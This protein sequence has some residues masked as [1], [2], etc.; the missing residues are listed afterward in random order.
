[1]AKV[2]IDTDDLRGAI[3]ELMQY[4][5]NLEVEK[6]LYPIRYRAKSWFFIVCA[7]FV[8]SIVIGFL[9]KDWTMFE[10]YRG[11]GIGC[12]MFLVPVWMDARKRCIETNNKWT[13]VLL[14]DE[15]TQV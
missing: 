13:L 2:E 3:L 5:V 6:A 10:N 7:F 15:K 8:A 12:I 1:M 14:D 9:W 11:F 4:N